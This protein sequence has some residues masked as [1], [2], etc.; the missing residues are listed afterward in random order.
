MTPKQVIE[1]W[2]LAFNESDAKGLGSLYDPEAINYQIPNE[3]VQ[4]RG[5]IEKMFEA[6]FAQADMTCIVENIFCDGDWA[7]LE[8]KDPFGLRGCGFFQIKS[9]L[10]RLQRGYWDKLSFLRA[11]N[12]PIPSQ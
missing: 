2:V 10:I 12:L 4:G 8:W 3:P 7:I 9:G 11:H 5:A 1:K 6:E